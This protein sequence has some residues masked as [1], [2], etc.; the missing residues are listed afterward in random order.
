[1]TMKSSPS[2]TPPELPANPK[3]FASPSQISITW[4]GCTTERLDQ[5][6]GKAAEPDRIFLYAPMNFAASWMLMLSAFSRESV[7]TLSTDLTKLADEIRIAA[8]IIF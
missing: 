3:V 2:F 5:L 4:T 6:M 7:L 1:M 8:P